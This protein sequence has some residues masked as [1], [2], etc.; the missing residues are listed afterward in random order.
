MDEELAD[1]V[2]EFQ[3]D[4]RRGI[5]MRLFGD[6]WVVLRGNGGQVELWSQEHKEWQRGDA[7][8]DKFLFPSYEIAWEHY[9]QNIR[10]MER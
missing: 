7:L 8:Q 4:Y 6:Y 1:L 9:K 2:S 3:L 10:S 5:Y